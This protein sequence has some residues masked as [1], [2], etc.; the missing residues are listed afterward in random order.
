MPY[1]PPFRITRL[2]HEF[3]FSSIQRPNDGDWIQFPPCLE[4]VGDVLVMPYGRQALECMA[5]TMRMQD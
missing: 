2:S 1:E 3:C 4:R 5:L